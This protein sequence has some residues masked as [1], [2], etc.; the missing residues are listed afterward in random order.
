MFHYL[1]LSGEA[2]CMAVL[3]HLYER[4]L[5]LREFLRHPMY[6]SVGHHHVK[7]GNH[8]ALQFLLSHGFNADAVDAQNNRTPLVLAACRARMPAMLEMLLSSGGNPTRRDK[9]GLNA[10]DLAAAQ[11]DCVA[12]Q[13]MLEAIP[14]DMSDYDLFLAIGRKRG[15]LISG[16]EVS[17]ERT[18]AMLLEEFRSSKIG[19][20]T[21]DRVE[22]P[23]RRTTNAGTNH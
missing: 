11:N 4:P 13:M 22:K 18:A 7:S 15:F 16:G 1:M 9:R 20:M 14:E 8:A 6:Y 19:K 12:M 10:I 2:D 23:E 5:E 21:L 3:F 17:E